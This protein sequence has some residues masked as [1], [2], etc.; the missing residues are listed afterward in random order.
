MNVEIIQDQ[1]KAIEVLRHVSRWMRANGLDFSEWWDPD[2]FSRDFFKPYAAP[3]D[4]YVAEVNGKPAAC[5]ILQN[6]Q[7][8]MQDWTSIDGESTPPALYLHYLAVDR[9]YANQ[10]ISQELL[11]FT[12]RLAKKLK[13]PRVRLDTNA[14]EP[15]LRKLYEDFGYKELII[16]EEENHGR[17]VLYE[18]II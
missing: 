2:R 14:D 4:F 6:T 15:K 3:E 13:L 8:N 5:I 1:D 18:K 10:G 12:D 16:L 11:K 7:Q 17:T 9:E